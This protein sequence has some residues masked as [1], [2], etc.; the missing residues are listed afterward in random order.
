MRLRGNGGFAD[1]LYQDSLPLSAGQRIQLSLAFRPIPALLLPGTEL[2]VR[3][4]NQWQDSLSC[5]EEATCH[6]I[7]RL[8]IPELDSLSWLITGGYDSTTFESKF[9]T[10][11][12]ENPFY[13]DDVDLKSVVDIDNVCLRQ[14]NFVS[15]KDE[16]GP[17]LNVRIFPNPNT[18]T[19][20]V[21]LPQPASPGTTF[22]IIDI[23]GRLALE[24][25]T[26]AGSAQ[27]TIQAGNLPNGLYFLQV[28]EEGKVLA[29]EK[30]VKQ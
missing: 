16:N 18:G 9:L 28:L 22:R 4:S 21:E 1:L 24:T 30:F 8:P 12:V 14:F 6:E 29:V 7:L 10:I 27:Q 11:H 23:T 26:G 17:L 20:T 15:A 19:F 25:K 5:P 2:V 13:A 3:V